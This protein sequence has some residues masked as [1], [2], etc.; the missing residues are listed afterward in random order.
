MHELPYRWE[1]T[2][3][4]IRGLVGSSWKRDK[5]TP[6]L[7][8]WEMRRNSH[9]TQLSVTEVS[10]VELATR[11]PS[12]KGSCG[13]APKVWKQGVQPRGEVYSSLK[14]T[15]NVMA[16]VGRAVPWSLQIEN[17]EKVRERIYFPVCIHLTRN[18]G[19]AQKA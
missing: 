13:N 16:I 15:Q 5:G 11:P 1:N 6:R 19:Q 9:R 2:A 17:R 3:E 8:S 14:G 18:R 4:S 12:R 10:L 7:K